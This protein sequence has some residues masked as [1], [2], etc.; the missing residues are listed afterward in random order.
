MK[1]N[2]QKRKKPPTRQEI[3]WAKEAVKDVFL[4]CVLNITLKNG[5]VCEK[6]FFEMTEKDIPEY[7]KLINDL[8]EVKNKFTS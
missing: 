8:F 5:G 1:S 4:S 2:N 7:S 6:Y 3:E